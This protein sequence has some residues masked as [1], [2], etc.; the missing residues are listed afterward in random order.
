MGRLGQEP[1]VRFLDGGSSV[2]NS[3]LAVNILGADGDTPPDW[4]KL[5][6]W[7]ETGQAFADAARKGDLVSVAGRVKT[8]SWTDR[9][10]GEIR[11][12]LMCRVEQWRVVEQNP[13][14]PARPD[15]AHAATPAPAADPFGGD[16][17]AA[18]PAPA[19]RPAAPARPP[20]EDDIPF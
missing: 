14:A 4:I 17:P 3:S 18:A 11:K 19:A 6:I 8:N 20:V 2:T 1:K 5:E 7:G 13:Q 15:P 16:A 10:T 12:E 9:E